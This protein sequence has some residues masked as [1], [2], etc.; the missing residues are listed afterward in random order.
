MKIFWPLLFAFIAA[1]GNALFAAGQKKA[2]V[3][4]NT[5]ALF[6][7]YPKITRTIRFTQ[8]RRRNKCIFILKLESITTNIRR[9]KFF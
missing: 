6:R 1:L 8:Q 2:V 3:F 5:F 4:D 9:L 7:N